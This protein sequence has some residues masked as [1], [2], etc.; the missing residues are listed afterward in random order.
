MTLPLTALLEQAGAK[1][2]GNKRADCPECDGRRTVSYADEVFYC[3][4][5]GWSGNAVMLARA[6][7]V[8]LP[9]LSNEALSRQRIIRRESERV[10]RFAQMRWAFL[11]DLNWRLLDIERL[12]RASGQEYIA[13]GEPVPESVWSSLE[14][15]LREQK[16]FWNELVL[17]AGP[18]SGSGEPERWAR[19]IAERYRQSRSAE[20]KAT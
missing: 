20:S 13:R 9:R 3:H 2:H 14:W 18:Q 16:K 6:L 4:K 11:R 17:F 1:L 12:A 15:S 8:E 19:I 5:C 10:Q 7:N